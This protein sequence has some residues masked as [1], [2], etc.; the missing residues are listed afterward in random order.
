MKNVNHNCALP[1]KL[2]ILVF[3]D[4]HQALCT[5]TY[6]ER[7]RALYVYGS[8]T[9]NFLYTKNDHGPKRPKHVAYMKIH[10]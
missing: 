4:H 1:F 2:Q 5:K 6:R 3:L 10:S 7:K 9:S 8:F